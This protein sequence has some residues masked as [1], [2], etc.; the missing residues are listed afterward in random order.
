MVS[1]ASKSYRL[2][3]LSGEYMR[4]S[5]FLVTPSPLKEKK[6]RKNQ[7]FT[8]EFL[9]FLPAPL[10]Y[11]IS[12]RKFCL[13]FFKFYNFRTLKGYPPILICVYSRINHYFVYPTFHLSTFGVFLV[14]LIYVF[15]SSRPSH[16]LHF[17]SLSFR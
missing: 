15:L 3:P 10:L 17:C 16:L 4:V 6:G 5:C 13:F 1:W 2:S 11:L 8:G 9:L 14:G 7:S 12:H